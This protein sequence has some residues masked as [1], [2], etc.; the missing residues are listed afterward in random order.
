MADYPSLG[1]TNSSIQPWLEFSHLLQWEKRVEIP[2]FEMRPCQLLAKH[3]ESNPA[4]DI[5][6]DGDQSRTYSPPTDSCEQVCWSSIW[7]LQDPHRPINLLNC[8]LWA[9]LATLNMEYTVRPY[10]SPNYELSE[11]PDPAKVVLKNFTALGLDSNN[12]RYLTDVRSQISWALANL[13]RRSRDLDSRGAAD[14]V[15]CSEQNLFSF[16]ENNHETGMQGIRSCVTAICK[17]RRL[18][19]DLGGIGVR[20]TCRC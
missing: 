16:G 10:S 6:Y 2:N 20:G 5:V 18:D 4:I 1:F 15:K 12:L 13:F 17:V 19:P 3:R 14:S 7:H 8:G 11:L 9:S